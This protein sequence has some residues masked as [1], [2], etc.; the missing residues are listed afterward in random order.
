LNHSLSPRTACPSA[1]TLAAFLEGKLDPS[2]REAVELHLVECPDCYELFLGAGGIL[3]D[4]ERGTEKTT[5]LAERKRPGWRWSMSGLASAAALVLVAG[6][7]WRLYAGGALDT[8]NLMASLGD[9]SSYT[10][11]R[12]RGR[13]MRGGSEAREPAQDLAV[14]VGATWLDLQLALAA[15]DAADGQTTSDALYRLATL[16]EKAGLL[17]PEV[18]RLRKLAA[19]VDFAAMQTALREIEPRL[20]ARFDPQRID[21]GALW[22]AARLAAIKGQP[23]FFER[24]KVRRGLDRSTQLPGLPEEAAK[25]LGE[26][27]KAWSLGAAPDP[28]L[29]ER[30]LLAFDR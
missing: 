1:E 14:G 27:A 24:R 15:G 19:A 21:T 22:E 9:P 12:W 2:T 13:V 5:S 11:E 26:A 18:G 10:G 4:F 23:D 17:G 8:E 7:S 20:R 29:F 30:A 6:L 3:G 28:E 25:A 16:C